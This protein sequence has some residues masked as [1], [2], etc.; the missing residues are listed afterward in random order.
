MYAYKSKFHRY[1]LLRIQNDLSK[2]SERYQ[3][4]QK[5]LSEILYLSYNIFR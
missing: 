4:N 5:Y 3:N 1:K 2:C